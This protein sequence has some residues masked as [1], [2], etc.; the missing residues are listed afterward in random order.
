MAKH[1][2]KIDLE[3]FNTFIT[4]KNIRTK[5]LIKNCEVGDIIVFSAY[6]NNCYLIGKNCVFEVM[7]IYENNEMDLKLIQQ[8]FE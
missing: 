8:H 2:I 1:E 5:Q 4:N 3:T 6:E 7:K